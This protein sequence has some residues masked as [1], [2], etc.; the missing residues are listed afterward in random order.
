M[1]NQVS[2]SD[3][4]CACLMPWDN[5]DAIPSYFISQKTWEFQY[6]SDNYFVRVWW[7]CN[8]TAKPYSIRFTGGEADGMFGF[9]IDSLI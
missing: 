1:I 9:Y 8:Q 7:I 4:S 3:G 2:Q 6:F 5:G